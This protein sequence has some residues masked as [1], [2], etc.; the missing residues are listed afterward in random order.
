M[1]QYTEKELKQIFENNSN[2]YADSDEVI[3]AMDRDKFIEVLKELNVVLSENSELAYCSYCLQTTNHI[4][5][6]CQKHK[7]ELK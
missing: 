6:I 1:K 3:M 7:N 2:C 5:N 4:N